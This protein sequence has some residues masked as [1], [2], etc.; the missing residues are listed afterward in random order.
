M[1]I[2]TLVEEFPDVALDLCLVALENILIP[3]IL[4]PAHYRLEERTKG[5]AYLNLSIIF[6]ITPKRDKTQAWRTRRAFLNSPLTLC[7][8]GNIL[9]PVHKGEWTDAG[10]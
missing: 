3:T 9:G 7:S 2:H 4:Y 8:R 6:G 1:G 10:S 5:E